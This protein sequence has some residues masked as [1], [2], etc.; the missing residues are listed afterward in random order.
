M[1][2]Q[3]AV[4]IETLVELGADV[5]GVQNIFSLDRAA[6]VAAKGI[7]VY[8]WKIM[9][10]KNLIGVLNKYLPGK[11]TIKYDFRHGGD[12]TNMV[13]DEFPEL[14]KDIKGLSEET[15]TG[16]HILREGKMVYH[17]QLMLMIQ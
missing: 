12:L 7:P 3:T 5:T 11:K 15:T 6:A 8:A 10:E 16:V 4:L 9:N 14:V 1:T 13:L 17:Q 2:I